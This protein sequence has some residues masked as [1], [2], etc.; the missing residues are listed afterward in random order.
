MRCQA[1][2]LAT[3]A[4]PAASCFASLHWF[5]RFLLPSAAPAR[6]AGMKRQGISQFKQKGQ[7]DSVPKQSNDAAREEPLP[8]SVTNTLSAAVQAAVSPTA[9]RNA[10]VL[11]VVRDRDGADVKIYYNEISNLSA[12]SVKMFKEV[13]RDGSGCVSLGE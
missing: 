5:C 3:P 12:D 9:I 2:R 11:Q 13:D 10:K 6:G 8:P 1:A 7:N 4:P